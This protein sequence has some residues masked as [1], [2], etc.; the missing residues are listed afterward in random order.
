[1]ADT[2]PNPG[3][4]EKDTPQSTTT[5][6]DTIRT[7]VAGAI[8]AA[9]ALGMLGTFGYAVLTLR[10]PVEKAPASSIP[11]GPWRG[12]ITWDNG[13]STAIWFRSK[14]GRVRQLTI[15]QPPRACTTEEPLAILMHATSDT[16][17]TRS[18][19]RGPW[20]IQATLESDIRVTGTATPQAPCTIAGDITAWPRN[21]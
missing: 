1:M 12:T 9:F 15:Y 17:A 20:T 18:T 14:N 21:S 8:A 5:R 19:N 10:E 2:R 3:A 7:A 4:V 13:S 6:T 16:L 11:D